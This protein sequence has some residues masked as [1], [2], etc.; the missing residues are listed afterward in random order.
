MEQKPLDF[1]GLAESIEV[2]YDDDPQ[3]LKDALN[4]SIASA[5]KKA[6]NNNKSAMVNITLKFKPAR[7]GEMYVEASVNNKE[8]KPASLPTHVFVDR[9][10]RLFAHDPQQLSFENVIPMNQAQEA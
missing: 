7:N 10:G 1:A 5:V 4:A 9:R 3:K 8:P 6:Y 2:V